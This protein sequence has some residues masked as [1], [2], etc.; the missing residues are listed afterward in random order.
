MNAPVS[1]PPDGVQPPV[2][3]GAA[4]PPADNAAVLERDLRVAGGVVA[5]VAGVVTAA[6]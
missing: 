1:P 2:G 5:V 3:G 6:A 4:R